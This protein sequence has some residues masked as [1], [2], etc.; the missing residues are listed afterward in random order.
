[1]KTSI[2]RPSQKKVRIKATTFASRLRNIVSRLAVLGFAGFAL[3]TFA[4]IVQAEPEIPHYAGKARL[5]SQTC[6][7]STCHGAAKPWANSA[8]LQ[9]EFVTWSTKDKHSEAYKALSSDRGKRIAKNLGIADATKEETCLNCHADNVP[10]AMQSKN[11]NIADGVGCEACHGGA[12]EWLGLHVSGFGQREDYLEAGIYPTEDPKARAKL[13]LSCHLSDPRKSI[14]HRIMGAGHPRIAFELDT[15]T[16]NQPAHYRIDADYKQRKQQST[17]V[18]VWA[19]GQAMA[20]QITVEA[21]MDKNRNSAGIFPELYFFDC[22]ACHHS[23]EEPRWQK[24]ESVN[25]GPGVPR[26]N[27]S[28]LVMLRV[29]AGAVDPASAKT[30]LSQTRALHQSAAKGQDANMKALNDLSKTITGLVDRFASTDFDTAAMWKIYDSL[31]SEGLR[32]EYVDLITAEQA[33]MA[34]GS[35]LTAIETT[36]NGGDLK[37]YNDALAK[38]YSAI[39]K[40]AEYKPATF[41]SALKSLQAARK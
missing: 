8:V 30:L 33:T 39:E 29:L 2:V 17:G 26:L 9:N 11:F 28:N 15:F 21:L 13:C 14:T 36:G 37:P 18:K 24:R 20:A 27:D 5:G 35:V 4:P 23:M 40:S 6:G 3:G 19:V 10:K 1:M 25:I 32:G 31:I 34:I 12:V 16:A 41:T 7:G 38:A 22:Y